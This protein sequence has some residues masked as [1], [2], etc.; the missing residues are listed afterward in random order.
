MIV[1]SF[2]TTKLDE[3]LIP[4]V[5]EAH[6]WYSR[7]YNSMQ[8]RE[9]FYYLQSLKYFGALSKALHGQGYTDIARQMKLS[10]SNVR[11]QL[12]ACQNKVKVYLK[13]KELGRL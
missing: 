6:E 5:A 13:L 11:N 4:Y 12:V 8:N 7:D 10:R 3:S 9:R 2:K 1:V